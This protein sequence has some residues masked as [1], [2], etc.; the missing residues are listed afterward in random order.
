MTGYAKSDYARQFAP[1]TLQEAKRRSREFAGDESGVMIAYS[2]FFLLIILMMAGMGVDFMHYEM[3]RTQLQNVLDNSVLAAAD[4]Q[5]DKD[6]ATVVE[7][8]FTKSGI[9]ATLTGAPQVDQGINHRRVRAGAELEVPTQF[10]HML[11]FDS[12]TAPAAS[13]AEEAIE[14]I[15]IVL[16]LDISGSM[17][18]NNR[19]VNLKPA[20]NEFVDSVLALTAPQDITISIVPYNT[21]VNAG[22]ELL[23]HYNVTN[24]HSYSNCINFEDAD[25]HTTGISTTHQYDRVGHFDPWFRNTKHSNTYSGNSHLSPGD[26]GYVYPPTVFPPTAASLTYSV[27]PVDDSSK[28]L[29]MS[30]NATELHNKIN[31]LVA[32]G[33]TSIDVAMK[34][35][36]ALIDPGTRPVVSGMIAAG[37]TAAVNAERPVNFDAP[38]TMKVIV[39]MT[40]GENTDQYMLP[41]EKKSG[42]SDVFYNA[43]ANQYSIRR[44]SGGNT[45]YFWSQT[46]GWHDHAFGD[47]SGEAGTPRQL[48]Y[49][50]LYAFNSVNEIYRE[51]YR[52]AIG[53][54]AAWA[55]WSWQS[56]PVVNPSVKDSRL[57]TICSAIKDEDALIYAIGF[58][59]TSNGNNQLRNCASTPAHFFNAQGLDIRDSFQAIAA[60]IAQLR[61]TQ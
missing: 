1:R 56:L 2:I 21:Q 8:Y 22:A 58:E 27:C 4:L 15:E 6:P 46:T 38:N 24:E 17:N 10:I 35:A 33:N 5:Q 40:D 14:G 9:D 48:S 7:D 44:V 3:K 47:G 39:V 18:R 41:P 12:L 50:E 43:A 31:S 51:I 34:W 49:P 55:N 42:P 32:N 30:N 23:S 52:P 25:F 37:D 59:A 61:L 57:Q 53:S 45:E 16:V 13:T 26:S 11:G 19:L 20:A 28:I 29:L 36:G 60:S 54:S